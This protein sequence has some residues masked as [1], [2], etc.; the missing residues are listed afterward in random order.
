MGKIYCICG[1]SSSGKDTVY[2]RLLADESLKLNQLVTYTTRPIREGEV[3]GREYFFIDEAQAIKL[4]EEG[5]IV[6]SRAY[7]T[8]FGIWKYM[9]VDDGDIELDHKSYV[10]IGTLE[11]YVQIRNY[12]GKDKVVPVMIDVDDG[13]RLERALKR[14]R[15]QPNPKYDEM[16][17]RFLA[18]SADFSEDKVRSAGIEKVFVNDVLEDCINSVREY[19]LSMEA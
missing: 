10:V 9:T 14:E 13:V 5:K 18:D 15:L 11:S 7:N 1:K 12:F 6:E 2:K 4:H 17:R 16:C 8:V 19:V 3:N